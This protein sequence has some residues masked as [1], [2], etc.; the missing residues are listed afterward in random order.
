MAS[1]D[2]TTD[3]PEIPPPQPPSGAA[4]NQRYGDVDSYV[5]SL[6]TDGLEY[7]SSNL[8]DL[9]DKR[10]EGI[11]YAETRRSQLALIGGALAAA[12]DALFPLSS[13]TQWAP[14]RVTC[15]VAASLTMMLGVLVWLLFAR[16]T[17]FNYPWLQSCVHNWKWFYWQALPNP[18][19]FGPGLIPYQR[20]STRREE[21]E[22]YERQWNVFREQ[23]RGLAN[24][25]VDATQDLK[26]LY[27]LHVDERYKNL[28]LTNLRRLL[29]IGVQIVILLTFVTFIV[30]LRWDNPNAQNNSDAVHS[31]VDVRSSWVPTGGVR[32]NGLGDEEIE[33]RVVVIITDHTATTF[34]AGHLVAFDADGRPIPVDFLMNPANVEV[35]PHDT[36]A[37]VGN[38][39]IAAAEQ[40]DLARIDAE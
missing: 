16:Q 31:G 21:A 1:D 32:A 13:L 23:A 29:I 30:T 28:F 18:I 26:Q 37:F 34:H 25:R 24:R 14:A 9:I 20:E 27:L 15:L 39:W 2:V 8:R 10:I 5:E 40:S 3:P 7:L 35:D 38:M 19:S 36:A 6:D 4:D 33:L 17:N 11:H 22:E 12:G